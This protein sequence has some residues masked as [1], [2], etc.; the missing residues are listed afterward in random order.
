MRD[1]H[2][3]AKTRADRPSSQTY[4]PT[5]HIWKVGR[6]TGVV[7]GLVRASRPPIF[8]WEVTPDL[9]LCTLDHL[10]AH[11]PCTPPLACVRRQTHRHSGFSRAFALLLT[12]FQHGRAL[13]GRNDPRAQEF[14]AC[15]ALS[16][17]LE[18]S[19]RVRSRISQGRLAVTRRLRGEKKPPPAGGAGPTYLPH[20]CRLVLSRQPC[21]PA[22][23]R[24]R[25]APVHQRTLNTTVWRCTRECRSRRRSA[26]PPAPRGTARCI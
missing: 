25:G 3:D 11:P 17:Y 12:R 15:D 14:K 23:S 8:G 4:L 24:A 2:T 7:T 20:R 26:S 19:S 10:L 9:L 16:S 13:L 18:H 5:H 22:G 6:R 21:A 1:G